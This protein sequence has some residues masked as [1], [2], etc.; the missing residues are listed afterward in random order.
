M[1][2]ISDKT[3]IKSTHRKIAK[4][5]ITDPTVLA[6]EYLQYKIEFG[7]KADISEMNAHKKK[8]KK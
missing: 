8:V 5:L 6:V 1:L 4:I 3:T 7:M 2:N